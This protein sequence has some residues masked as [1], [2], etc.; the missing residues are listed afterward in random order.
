MFNS[1]ANEIHPKRSRFS[2][3]SLEILVTTNGGFNKKHPTQQLLNLSNSLQINFRKVL[4]KFRLRSPVLTTILTPSLRHLFFRISI[5]VLGKINQCGNKQQTSFFESVMIV[6]KVQLS[7][8]C[9]C[10]DLEIELM[11]LSSFKNSRLSTN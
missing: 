1:R 11:S 10:S 3:S 6:C 5:M 2:V 4:R 7:Q 8:F 9:F